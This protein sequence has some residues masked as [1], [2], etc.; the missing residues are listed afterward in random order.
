M[1]G[2][3]TFLVTEQRLL[4]HEMSVAIPFGNWRVYQSRKVKEHRFLEKKERREN[5]DKK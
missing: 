1:V 2:K 3:D 5:L 4:D